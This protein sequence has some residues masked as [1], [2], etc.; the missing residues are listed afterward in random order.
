MGIETKRKDEPSSSTTL[1]LLP[2]LGGES[3]EPLSKLKSLPP[4][5]GE[6]AAELPK[7]EKSAFQKLEEFMILIVGDINVDFLVRIPRF[8]EYDDD[9]QVESLKLEG[10]GFAANTAYALKKLGTD[11]MLVGCV[12]NDQNGIVALESLNEIGVD[13]SKVIVKEGK[14]GICFSMIDKTGVR[15]LMTYPGVNFSFEFSDIPQDVIDK[16]KWVH[17]A[18]MRSDVAFKIILNSKKVSW[19]P[20]KILLESDINI[21]EE[22][23]HNVDYLI[24]NKVEWQIFNERD[25]KSV[26]KF[27][28]IIV[29]KG[30]EGVECYRHGEKFFDI[31]AFEAEAIDSTGA[32]DVFN[33]AFIHAMTTEKRDFKSSLFFATAAGAFSV[34]KFGARSGAP[35]VEDVLKVLKN[36]H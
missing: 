20:G 10:G 27:N 21:P 32:G 26:S 36:A 15:R 1:P 8:P 30:K 9:V 28:D 4:L 33:A 5:A 22:V 31:P 34:T 16:A 17:V 3:R 7:G 24:L 25:K 35:S 19:D 11:T 23:I 2:V 12:G 6:V 29:K 13:T 14:T 18:G